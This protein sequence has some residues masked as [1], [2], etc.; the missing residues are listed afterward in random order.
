MKKVKTATAEEQ[1]LLEQYLEE[2]KKTIADLKLQLE[3]AK[4]MCEVTS[5]DLSEKEKEHQNLDA[6]IVKLRKDLEKSQEEIKVISKYEGNT[7]NLD[8]ILSKHKQS[9]DISGLGFQEGQISNN[10]DTFDKEIQFTSSNEGEG[11]KTFTVNK[12]TDKKT[13]ADAARNR[14]TNQYT[15][16]INQRPY[17]MYRHADPRRNA[18]VDH[19]GFTRVSSMKGRPLVR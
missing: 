13:Y 3:E 8:K 14:H 2:S 9:K 19:E 12:D 4:R 17:S 18:C 16:S 6:E 10:K 7:E 15:Q 11:K 1:E 5:T